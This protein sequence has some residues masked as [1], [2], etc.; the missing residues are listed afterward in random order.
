MKEKLGVN[1][2]ALGRESQSL[3]YKLNLWRLRE[4]ELAL[5]SEQYRLLRQK[6]GLLEDTESQP[7][8]LES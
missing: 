1:E 8:N 3:Q 7:P 2:E 4:F 6:I 5:A